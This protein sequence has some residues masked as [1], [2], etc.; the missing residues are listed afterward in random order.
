M[1]Q[2]SV[3]SSSRNRSSSTSSILAKKSKI[4]KVNPL[5]PSS[6]GSSRRSTFADSQSASDSKK[7]S[8]NF[9][10]YNKYLILIAIISKLDPAA[11][12]SKSARNSSKNRSESPTAT[13]PGGSGLNQ[14]LS[15]EAD[16]ST[17]V[18]SSGRQ[19]STLLNFFPGFES[20][21]RLTR[22]LTKF[23]IFYSQVFVFR[24]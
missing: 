9:R 18:G 24:F 23:Q 4:T 1:D 3:G 21:R 2:F 6:A 13:Q 15:T 10:F 11:I 8:S 12:S 5:E 16:D 7:L 22:S 17:S 14:P 20:S 19:L